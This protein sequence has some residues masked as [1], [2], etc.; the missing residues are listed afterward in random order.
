ML[1]VEPQVAQRARPSDNCRHRS[2]EQDS[3]CYRTPSAGLRGD[4]F[5]KI[6]GDIA[7]SRKYVPQFETDQTSA[8]PQNL[9]LPWSF[10]KYENE[11]ISTL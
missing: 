4:I 10:E 6:Y 5:K 7:Q 8:R 2:P 11:I 3:P 9:S 1:E